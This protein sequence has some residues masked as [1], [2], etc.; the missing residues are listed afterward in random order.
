M[1]IY[2]LSSLKHI[3]NLEDIFEK[4]IKKWKSLKEIRVILEKL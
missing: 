3:N 2:F 4:R 1:I